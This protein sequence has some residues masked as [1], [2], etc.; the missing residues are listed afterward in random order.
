MHPLPSY[1]PLPPLIS[2]S[3]PSPNAP[4]LFS[5][6]YIHLYTPHH[7][8]IPFKCSYSYCVPALP[9]Y[10]LFSLFWTFFSHPPATS[11]LPHHSTSISIAFQSSPFPAW[12]IPSPCPC[13]PP[14]PHFRF[15]RQFMN[16]FLHVFLFHIIYKC[17]Y[18]IIGIEYR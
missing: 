18:M 3:L 14:C 16:T 5:H 10:P 13:L 7:Q 17:I 4:L 1:S 12:S 2:P 11:T 15:F 9:P 8:F 6:Y